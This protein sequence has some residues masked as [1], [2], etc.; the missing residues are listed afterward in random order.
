MNARSI[1]WGEVC[2]GMAISGEP[3]ILHASGEGRRRG[4]RGAVA[5]ASSDNDASTCVRMRSDGEKMEIEWSK[6]REL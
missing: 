6:G 1:Q 4:G 3:G 2:S 5:M